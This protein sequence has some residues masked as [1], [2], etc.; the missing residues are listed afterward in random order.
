MDNETFISLVSDFEIEGLEE[1]DTC[2]DIYMNTKNKNAYIEFLNFLSE[3]TDIQYNTSVL[4]NKNWN[5]EWENNFEPVIVNEKI[6]IRAVFH[7]AIPEVEKEIIIQPKMSFGTGHH[8][9]TSQ[10]LVVMQL[11]DFQNKKVLDLGSGTAILAIYAEMLGA[12]DIIALDNDAWCFENAKDNLQLNQCRHIVPLLGSIDAVAQQRFDII[13]ANIHKNF[14]IEHFDSYYKM[15]NNN[16]YLFLSG[17]YESDAKPILDKAL[18]YHLI[19]N[20][21]VAKNDWAVAVVGKFC[22]V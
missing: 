20:Y 1:K 17:F 10:M 19:S 15:L 12:S 16:G 6:A 9:T 11:I 21:Y 14:H 7:E 22:D 13:L 5:A 4:E 3:T 2:V 8:A 18:E